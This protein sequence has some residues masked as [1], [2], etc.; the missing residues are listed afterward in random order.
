MWFGILRILLSND[1]LINES[2]MLFFSLSLSIA[3]HICVPAK[4]DR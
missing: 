2:I 3:I 1:P 4:G